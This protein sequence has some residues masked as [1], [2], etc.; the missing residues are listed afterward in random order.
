VICF[1]SVYLTVKKV[2]K[3]TQ[4]NKIFRGFTWPQKSLLPTLTK[5]WPLPPIKPLQP[6]HKPVAPPPL[7]SQNLANLLPSP[8]SRA[9]L[10]PYAATLEP[11]EPTH[12]RPAAPHLLLPAAPRRA[13]QV[14]GVHPEC[15]GGG[16]EGRSRCALYISLREWGGEEWRWGC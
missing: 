3:A 13:G 10:P 5:E 4:I 8:P 1:L 12:P 14:Q 6:N 16:G 2:L 11:Q 15:Q 7:V 9:L